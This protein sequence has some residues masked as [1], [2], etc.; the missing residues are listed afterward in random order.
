MKK[1][2]GNRQRTI[3]NLF[4][5]SALAVAVLVIASPGISSA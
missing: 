5:I 4:V 1:G 3:G 2:R